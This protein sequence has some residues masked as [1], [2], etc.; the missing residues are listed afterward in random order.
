[1]HK[2]I[3]YPFNFLDSLTKPVL[4]YHNLNMILGAYDLATARVAPSCTR[5]RYTYLPIY[6]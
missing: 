6:G 2:L 5:N 4:V 1:M 3:G